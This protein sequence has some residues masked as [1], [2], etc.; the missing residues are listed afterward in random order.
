MPGKQSGPVPPTAAFVVLAG[1]SGTR[2]GADRNKVYLPLAGRPVISWS[3]DWASQVPAIGRVVMVV[4]PEDGELA[5]EAVAAA[6]LAAEVEIVAGGTTRHRSEQNAL[7]H[8]RPDIE[9]GAIDVVAIHDG[10]RPLSGAVLLAEIVAAAAEHGGA[11]PTLPEDTAWPV[12][13]EGRLRPPAAGISLHRVQTPQAFRAGPLLEVYDAATRAGAEGTD[14][15]AAFEGRDDV[16]VVSV[17]SHPDNLKV[18]FAADLGRAER[19]LRELFGAA[20]SRPGS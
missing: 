7:D 4:R 6:G 16:R 2:L 1:G 9:A 18:T 8:L 13:D 14:T 20:R 15:S 3:L 17:A 11:V 19:L 5:A 12:D 10:A